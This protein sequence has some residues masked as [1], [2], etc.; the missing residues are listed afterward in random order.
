MS[1]QLNALLFSNRFSH[2]WHFVCLYALLWYVSYWLAMMQAVISCFVFVYLY[3]FGR[4]FCHQ[5]CLDE[6]SDCDVWAALGKCHRDSHWMHAHCS[7]SCRTCSPFIH[8]SLN[9]YKALA[10]NDENERSIISHRVSLLNIFIK[11]HHL[12]SLRWTSSRTK[13]HGVFCTI[14]YWSNFRG[15]VCLWRNFD[16]KAGCVDGWALCG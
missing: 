6:Y 4:G 2:V 12:D 5:H 16:W 15:S 11:F 13:W 7:K 1:K 8:S 3:S 10:K 9:S 14:Q